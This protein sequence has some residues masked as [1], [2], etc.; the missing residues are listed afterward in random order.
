M[1]IRKPR[2]Y[3]LRKW[4]EEH[5]VERAEIGR[6]NLKKAWAKAKVTPTWRQER[7]WKEGGKRLG[8]MSKARR[9]EISE[10]VT[11]DW[12]DRRA[13]IAAAHRDDT[14]IVRTRHPSLSPEED[15]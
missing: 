12:A 6:A 4:Q 11:K 7:A 15:A 3:A 5:P 13:K 14:G 2:A 1:E 10:R 9:Q 8:A